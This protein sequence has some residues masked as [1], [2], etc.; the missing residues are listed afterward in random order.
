MLFIP[1]EVKEKLAKLENENKRLEAE[2]KKMERELLEPK[3][4]TKT[5]NL[6]WW[7][8]GALVLAIAYIIYVHVFV[9]SGQK[10]N[11]FEDAAAIEATI[12]KD[13][14]IEKWNAGA[15]L[16]IVYRVQLGAYENF[17]L[18]KYKQNLDGLQQ[19]SINGMTKVN[20]GAFS[21]LKD[22]QSFLDQMVRLGLINVYIVAYKNGAPIGLIEAQKTES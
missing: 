22:A 9:L 4:V 21:R 13:G 1:Q 7:S 10:N 14:K 3:P 19:D 12:I 20:L 17:N 5:L 8:I 16:E 11:L 2:N 15:D 18:D 6:N